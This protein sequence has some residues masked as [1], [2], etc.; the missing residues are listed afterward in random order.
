MSGYRIL[1]ALMFIWFDVSVLRGQCITTYPFVEDFESGTGNWV[2]GG[3]NGDWAHG[4]PNKPRITAAGSGSKCWITG[5]LS[6]ANYN[7]GQKSWLESPC[8]DFSALSRPYLSFLI[9][10]NLI[11]DYRE[12]ALSLLDFLIKLFL[13]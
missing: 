9:Y 7:G 2:P 4:S 5:G 1:L 10:F 13:T 12:R 8:F 6:N 11:P 3:A